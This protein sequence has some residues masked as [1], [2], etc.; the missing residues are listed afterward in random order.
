MHKYAWPIFKYVNRELICMTTTQQLNIFPLPH[1]RAVSPNQ[2]LISFCH[3][4]DP[5][6]YP[7]LLTRVCRLIFVIISDLRRT[8]MFTSKTKSGQLPACPL[9]SQSPKNSF[10]WRKHVPPTPIPHPDQNTTN[11]MSWQNLKRAK[12]MASI[13][14]E[15]TRLGWTVERRSTCQ[16][17]SM[18]I[19]QK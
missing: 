15:D 8:I 19:N 16:D 9:M 6:V 18:S 10:A 11:W 17:L 1:S 12:N 14:N 2:S 7:F 13:D 4:S 3:N 5:R